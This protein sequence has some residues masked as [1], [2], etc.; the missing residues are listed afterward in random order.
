MTTSPFGMTP[1]PLLSPQRTKA[2]S[3]SMFATAV[4]A[5]ALAWSTLAA[6]DLSV[7][8]HARVRPPLL[9]RGSR[10][11]GHAMLDELIDDVSMVSKNLARSESSIQFAFLA[12]TPTATASS[13]SCALRPGLGCRR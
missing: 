4:H 3:R 10:G 9:G 5:P 11:I 13:A 6:L 12:L 8:Q 2:S 1:P 7:F